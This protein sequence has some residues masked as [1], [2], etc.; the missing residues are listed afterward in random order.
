MC[1]RTARFS[2][3][4]CCSTAGIRRFGPGRSATGSRPATACLAGTSETVVPG[5]GPITDKNAVRALKDYFVTLTAEAR[6]RFDAGLSVEEA[7]RDI[8]GHP[9]TD[10]IDDER[11]FINVNALYRE[12]SRRRGQPGPDRRR[13]NEDLGHDGPLSQRAKGSRRPRPRALTI[14]RR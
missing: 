4:T 2:P 3:A 11:I 8:L 7:G 14:T 13:G 5:H 9:F 10:W 6:R 1:R 12:V